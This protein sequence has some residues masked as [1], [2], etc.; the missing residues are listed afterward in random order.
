[1][2]PVAVQPGLAQGHHAG[3]IEQGHDRVPVAHGRFRTGIGV[4]AD[5]RQEA[6][7]GF[8]QTDGRPAG[9]GGRAQ[10]DQA[11]HARS[12]RTGDDL[13][14]VGV[15]LLV[16]EMAVGVD[17]GVREQGAGSREQGVKGHI[18]LAVATDI[19]GEAPASAPRRSLA[20]ASRLGPIPKP[21]F[22]NWQPHKLP[23]LPSSPKWF[24]DRP[25]VW[26]C[27]LLPAPCSLLPTF[28]L[29]R[30]PTTRCVREDCRR[31]LRPAHARPGHQP[32]R[33]HTGQSLSGRD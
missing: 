1:M 5:R 29:P 28:R 7:V 30:L 10:R 25:L 33:R 4:N 9:G 22:P 13:R 15:E 32:T 21:V 17:H 3:M 6:R 2:V 20:D 8:R 14:A 27:S 16:V 12:G 31:P 26:I 24:W 23:S 18:S 19:K 11:L